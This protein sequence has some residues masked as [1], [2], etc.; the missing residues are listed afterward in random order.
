[1]T[2]PPE[3][4]T[5]ECP[6]CGKSYQDWWRPSINLAL[7]DFD[8]EY[9]DRASSAVCDHCDLKIYLNTLVVR[10]DGT[11]VLDTSDC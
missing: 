4:I 5:V 6:G 1:M 7:E 11:W 3:Q 8:E 10:E 2:S 9:L